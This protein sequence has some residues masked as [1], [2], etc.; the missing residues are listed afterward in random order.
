MRETFSSRAQTAEGDQPITCEG[1]DK[2]EETVAKNDNTVENHHEESIEGEEE[3]KKLDKG[4]QP[5]RAGDS[6][7]S[8]EIRGGGEVTSDTS[9]P[10]SLSHGHQNCSL[11][12][13]DGAGDSKK[14]GTLAKILPVKKQRTQERRIGEPEVSLPLAIEQP[15]ASTATRQETMPD[16][17]TRKKRDSPHKNTNANFGTTRLRLKGQQ[18]QRIIDVGQVKKANPHADARTAFPNPQTSEEAREDLGEDANHP[19]L[20]TNSICGENGSVNNLFSSL[21][22]SVN[23]TACFPKCPACKRNDETAT[24]A[25]SGANVDKHF[26][27]LGAEKDSPLWPGRGATMSVR[28]VSSDNVASNQS[29]QIYNSMRHKVPPNQDS[30]LQGNCNCGKVGVS[31]GAGEA[32]STAPTVATATPFKDQE[33]K[34]Y[35]SAK[36]K[37]LKAQD[38]GP[39]HEGKSRSSSISGSSEGSIEKAL[40]VEYANTSVGRGTHRSLRQA[41]QDAAVCTVSSFSQRGFKFG[42]K[43]KFKRKP[44]PFPI[45]SREFASVES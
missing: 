44:I 26:E 16:S 41:L 4:K 14:N 43:K 7:F 23:L 35:Q 13:V 22:D 19:R 39:C 12:P 27:C 20:A 34:D 5:E 45:S 2:E 31:R 25:T 33:Q 36:P 28:P 38:K 21:M 40:M 37:H 8:G 24:S 3:P 18:R 30:P 29:L 1:D 15:H 32:P 17:H 6:S 9:T 42:G 10:A 11:C